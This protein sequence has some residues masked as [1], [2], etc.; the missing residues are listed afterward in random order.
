MAIVLGRLVL[1]L[2][3]LLMIDSLSCLFTGKSANQ[4]LRYSIVGVANNLLG[5]LIYLFLT[6]L[7]LDPKVAVSLF[8]PIGAATAYFGHIKYSFSF[9]GSHIGG[10]LRY[11]VAHVIGYLVNILLLYI[12]VDKLLFPHQLVQAI[13]IVIVAGILF[14]LFRFFVFPNRY[15]KSRV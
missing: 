14:L 12:F 10:V 1:D 9:N 7:W 11:I 6:W 4:I 13:A 8:Y 15:V 5:Y 2:R 3:F